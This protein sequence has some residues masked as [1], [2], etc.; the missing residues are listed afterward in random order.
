MRQGSSSEGDVQHWW[1]PEAGKGIRT[2]YSD[3]LLWLA[4]VTADYIQCTGDHSI[5]DEQAG[6]LESDLLGRQ[7]MSAMISRAYPAKVRYI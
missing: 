6:Y 5:L 1:H 2:R 3:D 7:R 4:Y